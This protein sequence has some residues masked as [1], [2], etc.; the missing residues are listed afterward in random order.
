MQPL[1]ADDLISLVAFA[2]YQHD[3]AFASLADRVKDCL[4][5]VGQLDVRPRDPFQACFDV[6]DDRFRILGPRVVG[7]NYRYITH[8]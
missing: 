3:V 5:P 6:C 7:S 8:A 1:L 4:A 2:G